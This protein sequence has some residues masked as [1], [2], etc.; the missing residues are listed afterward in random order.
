LLTINLSEIPESRYVP[1]PE[2]IELDPRK[3]RG[4]GIWDTLGMYN[5]HKKLIII[6]DALILDEARKLTIRPE[7]REYAELTRL[8]VVYPLLREL[9]RLHEH[10]HA[11]I[12]TAKIE[13]APRVSGWYFKLPRDVDEPLTVFTAYQ[14]IEADE[15]LVKIFEEVDKRTPSYYKR[16]REIM[17]VSNAFHGKSCIVPLVKFARTKIWQ[18]WNDFYSNLKSKK[19]DLEVEVLATRFQRR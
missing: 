8:E 14:L 11:Y 10:S 18:D 6:C 13:G 5:P 1:R 4:E 15:R 12:H 2:R 7:L 3:C 16:W 19:D 17:N 9:V